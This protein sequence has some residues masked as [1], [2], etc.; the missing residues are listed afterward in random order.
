MELLI[1]KSGEGYIRFKGDDVLLV[2]LDKASVFPM[3][4]LAHVRQRAADLGPA[5]FK[6]VK[7][8]KLILIE[9]DL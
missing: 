1:V 2:Q 5:G 7:I 8:K 4:Q 9:E 3:D 6:T